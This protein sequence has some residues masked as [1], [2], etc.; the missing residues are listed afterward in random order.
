[1]A[2]F[3]YLERNRYLALLQNYRLASLALIALPAVAMEIGVFLFSFLGGFWR[4][5][6]RVWRYFCRRESWRKL[7][8]TRKQVQ[9]NRRVRDREV[10]AFFTGKVQ[11]ED[12]RSPLLKYVANPIFD[13]YWQ[14]VR[15]LIWW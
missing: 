1:M 5:K 10:T 13:A 15:R 11:F 2:K 7:L 4:E 8:A 12:L 14:I 3:Y 6:F 9:R